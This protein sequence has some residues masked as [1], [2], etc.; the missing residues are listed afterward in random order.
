MTREPLGLPRGSVRSLIVLVLVLAVIPVAIWA[1]ADGL[2][3]L[4]PLVTL[5]VRDYFAHRAQQNAIDGPTLPEPAT[6]DD[7]TSS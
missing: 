2:T 4:G 5:A 6:Y 3:L 7:P 1:P